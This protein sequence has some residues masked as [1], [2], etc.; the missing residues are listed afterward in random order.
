MLRGSAHTV[1]CL[2]ILISAVQV[3]LRCSPNTGCLGFV[4]KCGHTIVERV[5][6]ITRCTV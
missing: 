3:I 4:P 2:G 1:I 6:E 5:N